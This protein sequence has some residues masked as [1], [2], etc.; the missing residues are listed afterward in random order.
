[1][2]QSL[3]RIQPKSELREPDPE[4]YFTSALGL[5]FTDDTQNFYGDA[6][7]IVAYHSRRFDE[8]FALNTADPTGETER[9][10]FAH[11]VWNASLLMAELLGGKPNDLK[12]RPPIVAT[13]WEPTEHDWW[14]NEEE[15]LTWSVQGEKVLELGAGVYGQL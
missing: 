9:R 7:N 3:I 4:D 10:K 13:T 15:Q 1:M 11:Y 14:L 5:V 12:W 8:D 6:E 2:L